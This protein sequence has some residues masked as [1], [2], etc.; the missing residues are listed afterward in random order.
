MR[1]LLDTNVVIP[2]EPTSPA[3]V[4]AG[5]SA[6]VELLRVVSQGQ[7]T[8]LVHPA[9]LR[10]VS[11][12][13]DT[14]RRQLRTV[15]LGKYPVVQHPPSAST[16]LTAVLGAP[17][18]GSHD[19]IDL[20][21]LSVVEAN[22]VDYLV[23]EDDGI[24]RRARRVALDDRVLTVA[25]AIVAIQ[26][27]FPTV[28]RPPPLVESVLA[29]ELNESDPIFRS[30]RDDYLGFDGWLAKCKKQQRQAW[31]IG[32]T[33]GYAG[34]CI[35]KDESPNTY[36][37]AG[38][39]LKICSL[40]IANEFRGYRYGELLLKTIFSYLVE[41]RYTGVFVET[42]PKH[43]ALVSLLADFGFEDTGATTRGER[44]LFKSLVASEGEALPPLP[45][46]I[47]YGPYA[48]TLR[49]A[50]AFVAPIQPQFHQLLF[51][52]LERQLS[53]ASESHP[54]G[55]S[56]RK[57]YLCHSNIRKIRPG[58]AVLFYRSQDYQAITAMGVVEQTMVSADAAEV[59]RLV[60]KRTVYSFAEIQSMAGKP[61]F[62]LL[63]RLARSTPDAWKLDLLIRSGIV[64]RAPQS[65]ME[66]PEKAT[67]W[68]ASQLHVPR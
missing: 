51:P 22:A 48:V 39:V 57:A 7:H 55:N 27:L 43:D 54:F 17:P 25:D 2:A 21:L 33:A 18:A 68:I 28:P 46:N 35:I 50:R 65:F 29:H 37:F 53:I 3:D 61:I 15:L 32:G 6:V 67:D 58:D 4:E 40:K 38:K 56:I 8:A 52:E 10:E 34:V 60:G 66:L 47:K 49:G 64:K 5:T 19:E 24:H 12:D 45:F 59:A 36:G 1:F 16:R 23:T 14:V 31:V 41:N 30:F 63:F 62:V 42:F 20:L 26:A 44:V 11:G 13:R 9:S